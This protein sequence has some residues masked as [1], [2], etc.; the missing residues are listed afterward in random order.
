MLYWIENKGGSP[1]YEKEAEA[2]YRLARNTLALIR[3]VAE[4]S[5][6]QADF[7]LR[8]LE[9]KLE[10]FE[11][12]EN[13]AQYMLVYVLMNSEQKPRY[14]GASEIKAWRY[15]ERETG[16]MRFQFP[17]LPHTSLE[18]RHALRV[19][20]ILKPDS[21][22]RTN[23]V[24]ENGPEI[25]SLAKKSELIKETIELYQKTRERFECLYP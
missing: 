9:L 18:D 7:A 25:L 16:K 1:W 24:R 21:N 3:E 23:H 14:V 4:A 13:Y 20:R 8:L 12:Y 22:T 15:L 17:L 2:S 5:D 11:R 10:D 19:V 6:N